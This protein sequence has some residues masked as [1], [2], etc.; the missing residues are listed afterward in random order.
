MLQTKQKKLIDHLYCR[1]HR[2]GAV[3]TLPNIIQ[4]MYDLEHADEKEHRKGWGKYGLP[5]STAAKYFTVKHVFDGLAGKWQVK[6]ILMIRLACFYGQ[7]FAQE[8]RKAVEGEFTKE[9]IAA[10]LALDYAEM[11]S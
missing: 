11:G 1:L 4:K 5:I 7:A 3:V 2:L 10:L 9:E 6:D 8:Y